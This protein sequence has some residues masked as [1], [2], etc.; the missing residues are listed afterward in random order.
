MLGY[1]A[2]SDLIV[3]LQSWLRIMES[4]DCTTIYRTDRVTELL[5]IVETTKDRIVEFQSF[6][7]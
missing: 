3:E 6:Q 4:G 5:V 2:E 1:I 7:W